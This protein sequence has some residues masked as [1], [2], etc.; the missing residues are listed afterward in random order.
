MIH[1]L[2]MKTDKAIYKFAVF[3]P[4]LSTKLKKPLSYRLETTKKHNDR[5]LLVDGDV[6]MSGAAHW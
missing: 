3:S 1:S 6:L 5:Q 4:A 2:G